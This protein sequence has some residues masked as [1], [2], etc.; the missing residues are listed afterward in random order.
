ME[1]GKTGTGK[2]QEETFGA[3]EWVPFLDCDSFKVVY[4]CQNVSQST[5]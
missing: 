5:F 4:I 2:V 3:N 1:V